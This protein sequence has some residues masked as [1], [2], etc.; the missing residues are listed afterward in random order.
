MAPIFQTGDHT[1]PVEP[2]RPIEAALG[3]GE[4]ELRRNLAVRD[5]R[6]RKRTVAAGPLLFPQR[7]RRL[8]CRE[9]PAHDTGEGDQHLAHIAGHDNSRRDTRRV[10]R[11]R[12]NGGLETDT[13][14]EPCRVR[15]LA[16]L[17]PA[18]LPRLAFSNLS[19]TW[20]GAANGGRESDLGLHAEPR[21]AQERSAPLVCSFPGHLFMMR[22]I[23]RVD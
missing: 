16:L 9:Q 18:G 3:V 23:P 17:L 12:R 19:A 8:N 22:V 11:A 1:R 4:I 2:R 15:G 5:L 7:C 21:C 6:F 13:T 10:P 14:G 20:T